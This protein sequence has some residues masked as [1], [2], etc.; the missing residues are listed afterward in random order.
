L[1]VPFSTAGNCGIY[2]F[3][4]ETVEEARKLTDT[5]PA[6]QLGRLVMELHTWYGSAALKKVGEIHKQLAEKKI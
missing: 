5:D 4:V 2:I 3:D 6:I 1:Q